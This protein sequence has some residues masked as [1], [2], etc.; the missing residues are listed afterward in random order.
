[1]VAPYKPQPRCIAVLIRRVAGIPMVVGV[2]PSVLRAYRG[3]EVIWDLVCDEDEIDVNIVNFTPIGDEY[4]P[5]GLPWVGDDAGRRART[6]KHGGA[7]IKDK[8]RADAEQCDLMYE[9]R[10]NSEK[11]LDPE[12]QIRDAD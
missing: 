11:A 10:L 7:Q 4:R 5:S 8:V 12:I 9:V 2:T 3:D 1:M 6:R